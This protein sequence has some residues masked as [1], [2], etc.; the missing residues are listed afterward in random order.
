VANRDQGYSLNRYA[1]PIHRTRKEA[2]LLALPS[3]SDTLREYIARM[4][5]LTKSVT[6]RNA[7]IHR[8]QSERTD[9]RDKRPRKA[10]TRA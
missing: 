9:T 10:S 5:A 2:A 8:S 4:R 3:T 1:V 6:E 7:R